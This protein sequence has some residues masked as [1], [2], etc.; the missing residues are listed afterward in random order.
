MVQKNL[1]LV[2]DWYEFQHVNLNE[3]RGWLHNDGDCVMPIHAT[4]ETIKDDLEHVINH[5]E[6]DKKITGVVCD[7]G[8]SLETKTV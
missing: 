1:F 3:T 7:Q 8:S 2:G 4:V 6:F 5:F